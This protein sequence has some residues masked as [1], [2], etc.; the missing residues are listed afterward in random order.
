MSP[1]RIAIRHNANHDLWG[2]ETEEEARS[3]ANSFV[4]PQRWSPYGG[5]VD[6]V[7][8]LWWVRVP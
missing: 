8:G 7:G 5:S 1:K 4:D 2:Y 3:V 6:R